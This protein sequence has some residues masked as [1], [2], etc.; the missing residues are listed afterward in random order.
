LYMSVPAA[1][2][3]IRRPRLGD[4]SATGGLLSQM[5]DY[6][7]LRQYFN[8][9]KCRGRQGREAVSSM[10]TIGRTGPPRRPCKTSTQSPEL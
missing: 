5:I 10:A 9:S 7:A 6:L 2:R 1:L 4:G 3:Q 8:L